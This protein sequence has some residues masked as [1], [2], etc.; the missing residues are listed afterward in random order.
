[1]EAVCSVPPT[2]LEPSLPLRESLQA[3]IERRWESTRS[4]TRTPAPA[5]REPGDITIAATLRAGIGPPPLVPPAQGDRPPRLN[6][7]RPHD[8]CGVGPS[9]YRRRSDATAPLSTGP[10]SARRRSARGRH[11]V[12]Q[13]AADVDP[14]RRQQRVG[15]SRVAARRAHTPA[16]HVPAD[17]IRGPGCLPQTLCD[18]GPGRC[19]SRWLGSPSSSTGCRSRRRSPRCWPTSETTTRPTG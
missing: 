2:G 19:F 11:L 1:M 3:M 14:A 15:E 17:Q 16:Q 5:R 7:T 9:D 8:V 12:R 13:R 6:A 18:S 10:T 4:P